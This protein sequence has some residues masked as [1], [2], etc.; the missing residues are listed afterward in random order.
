MKKEEIDKEQILKFFSEALVLKNKVVS[1]KAQ[2]LDMYDEQGFLK[3]RYSAEN[4]TQI[5]DSLEKNVADFEKALSDF[6]GCFEITLKD[7][8]EHVAEYL[9]ATY[10]AKTALKIDK[11]PNSQYMLVKL[12]LKTDIPELG[13]S[14]KDCINL[15]VVDKKFNI[16]KTNI[17][18]SFFSSKAADVKIPL[19]HYRSEDSIMLVSEEKNEYS[20]KEFY[21]IT[22][23]YMQEKY[24]PDDYEVELE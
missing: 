18:N 5:M 14:K 3:P 9:K 22:K 6:K 19:L 21:E 2:M 7:Y 23:N 10:S 15:A 13:L 4:A 8:A 16:A 24:L 20:T 1:E 11:L 12:E 17:L